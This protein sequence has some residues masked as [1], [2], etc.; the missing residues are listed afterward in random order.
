MVE[1]LKKQAWLNDK[2]LHRLFET[3]EAAGGQIRIAGGAVR[4]GLW[5]LPISDID[6]ATTLTPDVVLNVCKKAG[7][8]VHPTG[9]QHGTITVVVDG[10]VVE[11]T[12]LRTDI[13]TDGRHAQVGFT[14]NWYDDAMRRDFTINALYCD[15]S[16]QVFDE[17]GC[18]L[19]DIRLKRIVFVGNAQQRIKEDYLRILRFFRFEARFGNGALDETGLAACVTLKQGLKSLSVERIWAELS[20]TL[21]AVR[22]YPIIA[23]MF[24]QG[25][26]QEL[27]DDVSV[28]SDL[29][30]L[31]EIEASHG[32]EPNAIRR[33]GCLTDDV[34]HW[35]LSGDEKSRFKGLKK[36]PDLSPLLDEQR[37]QVMLY[38]N[39][40]Q[41]F[42]D[43]CLMNWARSD[44][45]VDADDWM[46]LSQLP[47][48]W[49]IPT[50]PV[51]GKDLIGIGIKA[52]KEMGGMLSDLE[53]DW[54]HSGFSATK[55][56]LL[57]AV[58]AKR[59]N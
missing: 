34:S 10:L 44:S 50:F 46:M 11:V 5:G 23:E 59:L 7:F 37:Q 43:C 51:K 1:T 16:G 30:R 2:R 33:L 35:H 58:L 29:A 40:P 56:Q 18:G 8:V 36:L 28:S 31:Y 41:V 15:L 49:S 3:I 26:L 32:F 12:T 54:K 6:A 20:K 48:R 25:I 42:F 21:V 39:G 22:G 17:T 27:L 19:E 4:N 53:A 38:E 57:D 52:G 9:L 47:K 55:Q 45:D 13:K 24:N 14:T